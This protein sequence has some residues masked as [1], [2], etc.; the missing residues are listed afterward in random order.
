MNGSAFPEGAAIAVVGNVDADDGLG[1]GSAGAYDQTKNDGVKVRH[2]NAV[3]DVVARRGD[4]IH[5]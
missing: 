2:D 5:H 1:V 3:V 4:D